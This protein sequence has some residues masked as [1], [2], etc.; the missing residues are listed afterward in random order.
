MSKILSNSGDPVQPNS[1]EPASSE[2]E[3]VGSRLLR[4]RQAYGISQRELAKRAGVTN[5]AISMIEQDRVSPS[6][7]SLKKILEVFG[8]SLADFFAD[9]FEPDSQVFFRTAELAIIA[10]GLVVLRQVGSNMSKRQMQML[11]EIYAIGGDTGEV[12]LS[13]EGEEAGI[14]VRGEIEVTVGGQV[15]VLRR[16]DGYYFNS[17][18]PHRF[19]NIGDEECELVSSCTPPSF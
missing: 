6:V 13:H 17:R 7:A 5:G 9:D 19:R 4:L 3:A 8:L 16:G 14:V 10:D 1:K 18:L 2:S 11:H 12:L 15:E